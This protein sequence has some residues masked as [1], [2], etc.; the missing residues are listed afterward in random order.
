M[1]S[2]AGSRVLI[3]LKSTVTALAR[4]DPYSGGSDSRVCSA[5][6]PAG[7][8]PSFSNLKGNSS[9]CQAMVFYGKYR[10]GNP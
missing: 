3:A 8:V 10:P 9:L 2:R 1:A 7:S 6:S 4:D 5:T